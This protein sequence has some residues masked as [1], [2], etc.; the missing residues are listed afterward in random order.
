METEDEGIVTFNQTIMELKPGF[1][2][3]AK[4]DI[5]LLIRP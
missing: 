2:T 4:Q 5:I 3:E 1:A